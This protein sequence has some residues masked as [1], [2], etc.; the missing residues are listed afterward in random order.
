MFSCFHLRWASLAQALAL[1]LTS[2]YAPAAFR[3]MGCYPTQHAE[4]ILLRPAVR[5]I[6]TKVSP[7]GGKERPSRDHGGED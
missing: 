3:Y 1:L 7:S 2:S 4:I 5:K 6:K